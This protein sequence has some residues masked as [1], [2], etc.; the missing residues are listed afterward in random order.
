MQSAISVEVHVYAV[1]PLIRRL[2]TH[3]GFTVLVLGKTL[4]LK[5]AN[6]VGALQ[7]F[8]IWKLDNFVLSLL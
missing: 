5:D 8:K 2:K 7:Q 3:S 1:S 6:S 4:H